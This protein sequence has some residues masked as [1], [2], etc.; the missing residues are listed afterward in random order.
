MAVTESL[1]CLADG[2]VGTRGV[3]EEED[4]DTPPVTAADLY[5]PGGGSGEHLTTLP[6]W[7]MLPLVGGMPTGRRLL[8]LRDGML[9]REVTVGDSTMLSRRFACIARPG[10]AVLV[11]DID[12][13]LLKDHEAAR[14]PVTSTSHDE[15]HSAFGGGAVVTGSTR[16]SGNPTSHSGRQQVERIVVHLVSAT[17][18]PSRSEAAQLLTEATAAGASQL[19]AEQ[20]AAWDRRWSQ[21][22]VEV[23]GDPRSTIAARFA[24]FHLLSTVRPRGETAVG[25]RGLT[26]PAYA[27]HVFWDSEAFVL[28]AI[29]GVD[30]RSARTVLD[31][32]IRRLPAARQRAGLEGRSGARFPWESAHSGADVTPRSGIDHK[33]RTVPIRTGDLE[34]HVTADVAWAAWRYAAWIGDWSFLAGPGRPLVV[35]TARYWASRIRWDADRRAHIDSVTGPDEYHEC[36][37]DNAFTNLMARWNLRRAAELVERSQPGGGRGEDAEEAEVWRSAADALVDNFDP[38]THR[39]EQFDGFDRLQPLAAK[40]LGVPPFAADLVLGAER[41]AET[42]I[43]KQAD[44][45]M[46]HLLIP[47]GTAPGSLV[48]NLDHYLPRTAHGSSL[49]PAAHAVLLARAGRPS[50]ALDYLRLAAAVDLG[51]VTQTTGGGL[52]L[53]NLGGIWQAMVYGFAGLSVINPD[54]RALSLEPV[55]PEGWEELRIRVRWHRRWLRLVCRNEAVHVGTDRSLRVTVR[56]TTTRVEPPGRWVA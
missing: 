31:Y 47:E 49:S 1:L 26:G 30:S 27:G 20:R 36:V 16:W 45:L 40:D 43:I 7:C 13:A 56:G 2:T 4:P 10:T 42:Q 15:R 44:V 17:R 51:D 19:L 53:A 37:N 46:A 52:H 50:E 48:P 41:L 5:E 18:T 3:L 54:D 6:S 33:G 8:D 23:V 34:E 22:D 39:Y 29:A 32:R 55:L 28:P 25:A 38:V 21:A 24:I 35:D 11:A 14:D 9:T 12:P